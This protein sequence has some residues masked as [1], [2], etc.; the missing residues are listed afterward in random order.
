M[1]SSVD[2][3][4]QPLLNFPLILLDYL[5]NFTEA[6][7]KAKRGPVISAATVHHYYGNSATFTLQK[8]LDPTV[9]DS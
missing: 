7:A 1:K 5:H 3:S 2:A 8:F 4:P 6:Q 9:L